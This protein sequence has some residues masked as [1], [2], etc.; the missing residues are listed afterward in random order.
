M[1]AIRG[2]LYIRGILLSFN[3]ISRAAIFLSLASYVYC[4]N[5]FTA[6][7]VFIVASFFNNLYTS[8]LHFWPLALSS[9]AEAY[10]SVQRIEKYLLVPETKQR[11][12]RGANVNGEKEDD[13]LLTRKDTKI[14]NGSS[15]ILNKFPTTIVGQQRRMSRSMSSNA[16]GNKG[17]IFDNATALW[18]A[19]DDENKT[20][21]TYCTRFHLL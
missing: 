17:I 2:V 20:G 4:G 5:V 21:K 14:G 19:P 1:K 6:K 10:I 13:T 16:I 15:V 11:P 12:D 3:I 7:Q 18:S 9:V 8:M